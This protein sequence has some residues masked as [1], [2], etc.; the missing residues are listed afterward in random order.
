MTTKTCAGCKEL[1]SL[2]FD[3]WKVIVKSDNGAILWYCPPC[4]KSVC[5][6][7]ICSGKVAL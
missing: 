2:D 6:C 1:K 3:V 5:M 7:S 4:W